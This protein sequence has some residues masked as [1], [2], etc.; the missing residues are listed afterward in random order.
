ML[1]GYQEAQ[2]AAICE[3]TKL[4]MGPFF[5][6]QMSLSQIWDHSTGFAQSSFILAILIVNK[7]HSTP[8]L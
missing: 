5:W 1:D 4:K 3:Y 2:H 8:A 6:I 7:H